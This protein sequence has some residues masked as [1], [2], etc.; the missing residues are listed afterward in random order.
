MTMETDFDSLLE[1]HRRELQVH[2]Y[3]MLGSFTDAEDL[4]QETFLR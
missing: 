1:R 4:V 3:R 2:C